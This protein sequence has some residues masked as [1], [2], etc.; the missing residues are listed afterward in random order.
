MHLDGIPLDTLAGVT[1]LM[2]PAALL[3]YVNISCL[4]VIVQSVQSP[5]RDTQW[6]YISS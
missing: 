5:Q 4:N 6:Y 2:N 3:F 1:G